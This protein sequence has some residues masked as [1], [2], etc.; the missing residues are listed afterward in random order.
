MILNYPY[1][2]VRL[3]CRY[4][5]RV[6]RPA[7]GAARG[8][9]PA[10]EPNWR[11]PEGCGVFLPDLRGAPPD[12]ARAVPHRALCLIDGGENKPG[13]GGPDGA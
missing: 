4:C 10:H 11:W 8:R 6:G 13:N 9:L 12:D 5:A 3:T 1:V 7:A 2:V